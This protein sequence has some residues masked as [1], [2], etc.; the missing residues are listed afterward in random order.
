MNEVTS[1]WNYAPWR[2]CISLVCVSSRGEM[3]S[4]G[5]EGSLQISTELFSV[6]SFILYGGQSGLEVTRPS[7]VRQEGSLNALTTVRMNDVNRV[8]PIIY[9]GLHSRHLE[10]NSG[11]W[12]FPIIQHHM[13]S[14]LLG[15]VVSLPAVTFRESM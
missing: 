3:L 11:F 9:C 5:I 15:R 8:Y 2:P 13:K 4:T 7:S 12:P 1:W 14:Y 10:G 6:I